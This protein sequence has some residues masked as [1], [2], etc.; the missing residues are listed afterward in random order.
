[1]NLTEADVNSHLEVDVAD[2][3]QPSR[4]FPAPG[5]DCVAFLHVQKCYTG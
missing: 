1:M 3:M 5:Q 2:S 4:F